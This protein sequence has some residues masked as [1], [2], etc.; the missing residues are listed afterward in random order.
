MAELASQSDIFSLRVN[1][2][3]YNEFFGTNIELDSSSLNKT[4]PIFQEKL[5]NNKPLLFDFKFKKPKISFSEFGSNINM[6]FILCLTVKFDVTLNEQDIFSDKYRA[7]TSTEDK[8]LMYDELPFE[9]SLNTQFAKNSRNGTLD[10]ILDYTKIQLAQGD[11]YGRAKDYPHRNKMNMT[12]NDYLSFL[13]DF[14]RYMEQFR[15]DINRKYYTQGFPFHKAY[16]ELDTQ[17]MFKKDAAYFVFYDKT[18]G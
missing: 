3:N 8:E 17:L 12:P 1:T 6:E 7:T 18:L 5:G 10:A 13:T 2:R 11:L 16:D 9:V 15:I 4:F 14:E